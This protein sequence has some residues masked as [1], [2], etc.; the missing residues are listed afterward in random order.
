[1]LTRINERLAA[2]S[3]SAAEASRRATGS[4]DTIRDIRRGVDGTHAKRRGVSTTTLAR[5]AEVLETTPEWLLN[6]TT[7]EQAAPSTGGSTEQEPAGTDDIPVV[8]M[9]SGAL[10]NGATQQSEFAI[11]YVPR[12]RPLRG[13]RGVYG[14]YVVNDSMAPE[15]RAGDLRIVHPGKPPRPGDTVLVHVRPSPHEPA[16]VFI[17]RLIRRTETDIICE[18]INPPAKIEYKS[19]FV[20]ALH[21][22]LNTNE[23]FGV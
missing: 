4:P 12:P 19:Q 23:I 18:Q 14:V 15:H 5:L 11:D 21:K 2:L 10:L 3:M 16:Q 7:A 17:K 13:A 1:M 22:V 9:A 8:G 6:G 20:T